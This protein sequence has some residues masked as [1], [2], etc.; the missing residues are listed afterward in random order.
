MEVTVA[1]AARGQLVQVGCLAD[2]R[3]VASKGRESHVVE[4]NVHNIRRAFWR[5]GLWRPVKRPSTT[6]TVKTRSRFREVTRE[7]RQQREKRC[8]YRNALPIV[9]QLLATV[10]DVA[11][12]I[13]RPMTGTL[14]VDVSPLQ[15]KT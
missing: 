4:H 6:G 5:R 14:P 7:F 2:G 11:G 1:D 12:V 9:R 8:P 15:D 10:N 3:A 13:C